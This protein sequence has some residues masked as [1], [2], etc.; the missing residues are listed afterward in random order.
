MLLKGD[1]LPET[2]SE[3]GVLTYCHTGCLAVTVFLTTPF[4]GHMLMDQAVLSCG[5]QA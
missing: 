1:Y 4:F 2:L 3:L 5:E